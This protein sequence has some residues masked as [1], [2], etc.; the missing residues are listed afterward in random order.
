MVADSLRPSLVAVTLA[1]PALTAVTR[2]VGLTVAT[3]ALSLAHVTTRSVSGFPAGSRGIAVSCLVCPTV[4]SRLVGVRLTPSTG[5]GTELTV[6]EPLRPSLLAVTVTVPVPTAVT[7][8]SAVTVATAGSAL[9]QVTTR[10]VSGF[11][12]ASRSVALS[13]LIWLTVSSRFG[14]VTLTA[15]TGTDPPVGPGSLHDPIATVNRT[16][17][18]RRV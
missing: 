16:A 8:P 10:S 9:V 3:A 13:V 2:P 12:A 5:I 6:A 11:P 1:A 17:S 4:R 18:A 14:G 7:T 15:A